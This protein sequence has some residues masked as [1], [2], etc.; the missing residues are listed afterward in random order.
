MDVQH[1]GGGGCCCFED[2]IGV[3][4]KMKG[5]WTWVRIQ[6][7][8]ITIQ[9]VLNN[10]MGEAGRTATTRTESRSKKLLAH[11]TLSRS[12]AKIFFCSMHAYKVTSLP[13][14]LP[15]GNRAAT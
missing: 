14:F 7:Q 6:K 9:H 2:Q 11:S 12:V 13:N 8:R 5:G 10:A 4:G 3:K 15:L 1:D